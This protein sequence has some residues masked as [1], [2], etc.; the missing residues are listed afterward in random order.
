MGG[1][2]GGEVGEVWAREG[3]VVYEAY[4]KKRGGELRCLLLRKKKN[5]VLYLCKSLHG[6][7]KKKPQTILLGV[8]MVCVWVCV[9]VCV[10]VGVCV[11]VCVCA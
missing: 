5:I 10:C 8:G 4:E 6:E 1:G 11:C 2:V 3:W 7:N 9:C